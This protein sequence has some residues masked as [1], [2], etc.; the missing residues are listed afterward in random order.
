MSK[1]RAHWCLTIKKSDVDTLFSPAGRELFQDNIGIKDGVSIVFAEKKYRL[2]IG[3]MEGS[4]EATQDDHY[5]CM[6]SC[7][8]GNAC[9]KGR[10]VNILDSNGM[11]IGPCYVQELDSTPANYI[12]YMFKSIN[13]NRFKTID[14]ILETMINEMK[15]DGNQVNRKVYIDKLLSEYG[16]TW[17]TKNKKIID[18]FVNSTM[19]FDARRIVQEPVD[20]QQ[21]KLRTE[22]IFKCYMQTILSNVADNSIRCEHAIFKRMSKKQITDCIGIISIIPYLFQRSEQVDNIPGLYFYGE[23]GSGK[24][25][26]FSCGKSYKQVSTD[27][28]GVGRFKLEGNQSAL[29]F[30]DIPSKYFD[31]E[32]NM[33]TL[34]Q[35]ALGGTSRIKTHGDSQQIV[36]FIVATSNDPPPY[37]D[38][39]YDNNQA[40]AWLRRFVSL[41][42]NTK[43]F[44]DFDVMSGTEFDYQAGQELLASY[45]IG[46]YKR[47]SEECPHIVPYFFKYYTQAQKYITHDDE[48][49]PIDYED[50][51]PNKKQRFDE[52]EYSDVESDDDAE[53]VAKHPKY[54]ETVFMR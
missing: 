47:L 23:P 33:S 45:L 32:S 7:T 38:T 37:L 43:N 46:L 36:A 19:L 6:V 54:D 4:D 1:Q 8:P 20:I 48:I 27:S 44:K 18:T 3:P 30:D 49:V 9:T 34:R 5:H 25:F 21:I 28:A 31:D 42:F 41:K 35:L 53:P 17:V 14:N 26:F 40:G 39:S 51:P 29:L 15:T 50:E 16:A 11:K 13:A 22:R 10:V 52:P 2:I 12:N 24:S